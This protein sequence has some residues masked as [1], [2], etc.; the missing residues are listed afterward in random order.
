MNRETVPENYTLPLA[1]FDAVPVVLFG[2]ACWIL[3]KISGSILLFLGGT[4][5]FIAGLLKVLWKLI[6]ALKKK[7]IWPLFVQMRIGMPIGFLLLLIGFVYACITR[8]MKPFWSALFHPAP[9]LFLVL[10]C[11]GMIAMIV[12]GS[13]L[14]AADVKANWLEESCNTVAQGA[15]FA[16]MLLTWIGIQ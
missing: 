3:W 4:I 5:C 2:L 10:S 15:F 14:D 12:C 11:L 6:V 16:A 8:V 13:R 9:I 1:L 7:N